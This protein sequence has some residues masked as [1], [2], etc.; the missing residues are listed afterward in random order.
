MS[1]PAKVHLIISGNE[2]NITS[3]G[4]PEKDTISYVYAFFALHQTPSRR[5]DYKVG[6]NLENRSLTVVC[7]CLSPEGE[8]KHLEN[9]SMLRHCDN[10]NHTMAQLL[11]Q[12]IQS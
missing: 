11:A 8:N 2:R 5:W 10:I 6:Y 3:D 1:Q 9:R 12:M 7:S 4:G